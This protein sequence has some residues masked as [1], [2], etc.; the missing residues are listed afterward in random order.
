MATKQKFYTNNPCLLAYNTCEKI[1]I[2][3][4]SIGCAQDDADVVYGSMNN[5]NYMAG[6]HYLSCAKHE[7]ENYQLMPERILSWADGGY[8]NNHLISI[9]ICESK[10]M[11]YTAGANYVI[12]NQHQFL[13]DIKRGYTN[14]V[15]L[16]AEICERYGWNPLSKLPS[17]LYLISSHDEGRKAGLSTSHVDPSHIWDKAGLS[18][19][20]FRQDVAELMKK[21]QADQKT[22]PEESGTFQDE[23]A[24][25]YR[26]Q[27][28]AYKNKEYAEI[29]LEKIKKAGYTDAF[30]KKIG[31]YYKVQ[32]G[33]F[34]MR[35]NA[36]KLQK[37]L[38]ALGEKVFVTKDAVKAENYQTWVGKVTC[39]SLNVR[40]GPGVD[41]PLLPEYPELR[42]GNLVDVVA[43]EDDWY[44]V[45]IAGI[46]YGYV[47]KNYIGRA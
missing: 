27:V 1:G 24:Y 9:E 32:I 37:E 19:D 10:A 29:H 18:M 35:E 46:H 8:G 14:A 44:K 36:E 15:Q 12:T 21:E 40:S 34:T 26:V 28:G 25:W 13:A 3:I 39:N 2:Q 38:E 47:N 42:S 43:Q 33:A 17:G 11:Y 16:C 23:K 5:R 20:K 6:V 22:E 45:R 30:V 31:D 41:Y 7:N 4:H